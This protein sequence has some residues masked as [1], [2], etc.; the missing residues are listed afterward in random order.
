MDKIDQRL[1]KLYKNWEAEYKDATTSD[2][3]EEI[4]KFYKLYLEKYESKY[5]I[6]YQILQQDNELVGQTHLLSTQ[7]PDSGITPS[8][9]VLDYA[10][11]LRWKEL[12]RGELGEDMPR[13]YSSISGHLTPTLPRHEDMRLDSTFNVTPEG[14][15]GNLPAAVGGMEDGKEGSH[16]IS[17]ER[18]QGGPPTNVRTS[19]EGTPETLLKV[20]PENDVN[21]VESPR[22]IQRSREASRE[23]AIASTKQFF[24]S[25]NKRNRSITM[26]GPHLMLLEGMQTMYLLFL[27]LPLL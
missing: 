22:R 3:C 12:Q 8:L 1:D 6:L 13:Q 23:D 19:I 27:L 25:V 11:A 14:S 10:Q 2:E 24:A 20:A 9:A 7:E 21:L 26:E 18:L 17:E 4:R 16:Q 5:R 15:L